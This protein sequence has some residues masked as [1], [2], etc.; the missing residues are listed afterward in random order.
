MRY[1]KFIKPGDTLGFAAPSFGCAI[2]PYKSA[3]ANA[4]KKF[5]DM[6]YET[7]L[8]PNVYASD[9]IGISSTPENC[10]RE[11]TEM[12]C[13][14]L[15]RCSAIFSCGGGELMCETLEYIDLDR[16]KAAEPVWY[17]GYSDNTNFVFPLVTM[18][19]TAALYAPCAPTF[20]M[21][22]W[23]KNL[24]D[25]IELLT[26]VRHSVRTYGKWEKESL[27]TEKKP[28]TPYNCTEKTVLKLWLPEDGCTRGMS[29]LYANAVSSYTSAERRASMRG[30]LLGG[31]LDSLINLCGTRFDHVAEFSYKYAD[32]GIIWF[33]EACDLNVISIRRALWQL[34]Q[35]GWFENASGFIIGRPYHFNEPMMGLDQYSAVLDILSEHDVPV[36]MDADIG[37]LPPMMPL[38]VGSLAE[39]RAEGN[40][41]TVNMELV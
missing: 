39:V 16:I 32:D 21:E 26:G 29:R 23:H 14:D 36:I 30:R 10:A 17:N 12:Y 4:L 27:K 9:G 19:D 13:G 38:V 8:G 40:V 3:F 18:C 20:G 35:A 34:E 15:G 7:L 5:K 6:G 11:L 41:V 31:C 1:P 37:H 33:L 2:E 25:N 28:L 24:Q 22:P